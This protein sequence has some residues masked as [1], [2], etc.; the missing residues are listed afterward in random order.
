MVTRH[1]KIIFAT[2][3]V[4][5][6]TLQVH[7]EAGGSIIDD[8]R[9]FL[10]EEYSLISCNTN[11][12]Y[13]RLGV[14]GS[15]GNIAGSDRFLR[16]LNANGK[17]VTTARTIHLKYSSQSKPGS[18]ENAIFGGVYQGVGIS[19]NYFGNTR[20]LG[21]PWSV[22]I[23]QGGKIISIIP[24]LS[25]LYE[26]NF[27]LSFGWEPFDETRNP[28]NRSIG[29]DIN[30]YLDADFYFSYNITRRIDLTAGVSFSHYSNGNTRHPNS[31]VNVV[32]GSVGLIYNFSDEDKRFALRDSRIFTK[33]PYPRHMVYE[34][35]I[36]GSWK[37]KGIIPETNGDMPKNSKAFGIAGVSFAP[38]Y[39]LHH[40]LKAGVSADLVY[41]SS[42]KVNYDYNTDS[43]SHPDKGSQFSLGLSGKVDYAMPYF[44][45]SAGV[46]YEVIHANDE[47][48]SFYQTLSLKVNATNDIFF[49]VGYRVRNFS[50]PNFLMLGVGCRFSSYR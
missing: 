12:Y 19:K 49:N 41:D 24:G 15:V 6:A 2:L 29:S 22:Y 18:W 16:G 45:I 4:S 33:I 31:G 30:A 3:L 37:R 48:K 38:M 13:H 7:A 28:Y 36:Y 11:E 47:Y 5:T 23:L 27:G 14:S 35:L 50:M 20:E 9:I 34:L 42:V 46:G 8:E 10:A 21:N 25:L 40:R 26:W 44:T 43:Y 32:A 17:A 1:I 39:S